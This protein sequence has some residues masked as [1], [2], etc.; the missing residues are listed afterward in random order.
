M[1]E[2]WFDGPGVHRWRDVGEPGPPGPGAALVRPLAVACCDLDVW[3]NA[4]AAGRALRAPHR[5]GHEGV[6]EVVAV[7]D[8]VRTRVGARVVVPFQVSCGAC[9]PCRRGATGSCASVPPLAGYGLGPISGLDA[10]GL[11][12]DLVAVPFA[13]AMLLPLPDGVDPVAAASASDNL[14]DGYR[15][16]GVHAAELAALDA[17]DRRVLVL[18]NGSIGLYA[19]A[20]GVALGAAVD[21]VDDD[22][23]RRE[24]AERLGARAGEHVPAEQYPVVVS[25]RPASLLAALDATWPGGVCTDTGISYRPVELPLLAMYTRGVRFVT[26][27]ADARAH[28]PAVLDLLAS[29]RLDPAPVTERVVGWDEAPAAWSTMT[30]KVVVARG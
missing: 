24:R 14:P 18:G 13:D 9:G 23:G 30:G 12:A 19:A 17:A 2:L 5:V 22:P 1:D 7:G 10:G 28:L 11:L 15:T 26:G 3:A 27:R 25:T 6:A 29:G 4:G 20:V 21:Y 16:V 8:G